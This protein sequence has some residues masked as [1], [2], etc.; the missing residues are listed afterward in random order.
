VKAQ[1]S[2]DTASIP[3]ELREN[4]H[5]IKR[6]EEIRFDVKDVDRAIYTVHRVYTVLNE[7]G[8]HKLFFG[9]HTTKYRKIEEFEIKGYDANGKQLE[10]FKKRDLTRQAILDGLATDGSYYY[11][12]LGASKY[13]AT[14]EYKYEIEYS[15]TAWYPD[16]YLQ[17]PGESVEHSSFT[18]TIP[19]NLDL[20]FKA[21]NTA[22]KPVVNSNGAF[23]SYSWNI[24]NLA[25]MSSEESEAE[26]VYH[27][28]VIALAPNKFRLYNTYGDMSTWKSFGV[29][30]Y[31][32][33]QGLEKLSE[34]RKQFFT[35]LVKDAK[36]D[37]DKAAIVYEYLQKNFR[38]VSIQ[39]GI[40]GYKPFPVSFTDEKKYGDC[41]GLSFFMYSVLKHLGVKSYCALVYRDYDQYPNDPD[42]AYN[43]FNH[44]ILCIPQKSDSIWLECTSNTADF[45]VLDAT[46]SDKNALLLTENG[47]VLVPTPRGQAMQ[48][49]L[50][51]STEL[52]LEADGS[53]KSRTAL[54]TRGRFRD[55]ML[56]FAEAKRDDQKEF[57][58]RTLGFKHP[59]DFIVSQ[60]SKTERHE[61]EIDTYVEKVPQFMAGSK[62]F[63]AP[64]LNTLW[65]SKLPSSEKRKT[66]FYFL[67]PFLRIDTTV[68]HLPEG[69]TTEVLPK[70]SVIKCDLVEYSF[71]CVYD[72]ANRT[73]ISIGRLQLNRNR[74]PAERYAE[75]KACFDRVLSSETQKLVIRKS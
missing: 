45:G 6:F 9:E 74:I 38:Y 5:V 24:K 27:A 60:K 43:R 15:G 52:W 55:W 13:P 2:Y 3:K 36:S 66:D 10:R 39:L 44:M 48:N 33:L 35:N 47:G 29:W 56:D 57:L 65:N 8:A 67:S 17:E 61:M 75:V 4:A 62:M 70:A 50:I 51:S 64:R 20:R 58:V 14:I 16:Y 68:Y 28:P 46:T 31:E 30:G 49:T 72:E 11:I 71:E 19:A 69:F 7:K 26:G 25:A 40:G 12:R 54:L 34:D 18:A 42:F 73:V 32:L 1:P 37:R 41:K 21:M 22:I 63:L 53:A 59:D 23:K